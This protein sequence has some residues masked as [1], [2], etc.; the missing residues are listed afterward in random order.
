[1]EIILSMWGVEGEEELVAAHLLGQIKPPNQVINP[2]PLLC[3]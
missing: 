3:S 2:L 1:M